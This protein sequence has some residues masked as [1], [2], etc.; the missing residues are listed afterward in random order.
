MTPAREKAKRKALINRVLGVL[1]A[2][3][4]GEV[5]CVSTSIVERVTKS[6][7]SSWS[8]AHVD[9]RLSNGWRVT[10]FFDGGD[11]WDDL[12]YI[13]SAM[14]PDGEKWDNDFDFLEWPEADID[15]LT[16]RNLTYE[17]WRPRSQS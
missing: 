17:K 2:V 13:D 12:D 9:F 6:G 16:G 8:Y 5:W 3:E 10:F 7:W 11:G 14:T 1:R 15:L 4:A